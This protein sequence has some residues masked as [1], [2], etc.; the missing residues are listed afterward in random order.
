MVEN[1]LYLIWV[2][3]ETTGLNPFQ[4]KIL[5]ICCVIT[6]RN[7]NIEASSKNLVI[8]TDICYMNDWCVK[9]HSEN[10]LIEDVL[11]S[12]LNIQEAETKLLKFLQSWS[13]YK[14]SPMCG[15]SVHFD[16]SFLRVHMPLVEDYF[17]Y[18]NI[19]VSSFKE[20]THRWYDVDY[21]KSKS[22]HRAESDIIQSIK[23]LSFYRRNYFI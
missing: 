23:E 1:E 10:G 9:T 19:D 13:D 6:D 15:S 7:L 21:F 4:D 20:V 17:T 14:K 16:R 8:N 3:I 2:D 11:N 22:N 18:R 5:E 12:T